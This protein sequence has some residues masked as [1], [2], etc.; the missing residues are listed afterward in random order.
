MY[1]E[2]KYQQFP[3]LHAKQAFRI[4]HKFD[5]FPQ[6]SSKYRKV[7]TKKVERVHI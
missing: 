6:K 5:G 4:P 2:Y 3:A 1:G 7:N